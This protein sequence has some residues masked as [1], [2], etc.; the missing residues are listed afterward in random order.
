ME[1]TEQFV[2]DAN[3]NVQSAADDQNQS[4]DN[5]NSN[6]DLSPNSNVIR[7]LQTY[8]VRQVA[9]LKISFPF[10]VLD[11]HTILRIFRHEIFQTQWKNYLLSTR[12]LFLCKTL[13]LSL[14][15]IIQF[16]NSQIDM[17]IFTSK[18][19]LTINII[20]KSHLHLKFSLLKQMELL[21]SCKSDVL[22]KQL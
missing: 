20:V 2:F 9:S 10:T 6:E 14:I 16:S 22:K 19:L 8:F 15:I 7:Y 17:K 18:I 13:I 12:M 3:L 4:A 11:S 5:K 21:R 1:S